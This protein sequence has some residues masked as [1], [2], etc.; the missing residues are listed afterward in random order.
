MGILVK[1]IRIRNFRS[2]ESLDLELGSTNLLIGQNNTGKSNF[3]CAVN[4]ALGLM[5]DFSEADIYVTDGE[6]LAKTKGATIDIYIYP[7]DDEGNRTA[8]FTDFWASVFTEKWIGTSLEGSFV[9][10]RAEI[11]LD[12]DRENYAVSRKCI[13]QWGDE[14]ERTVTKSQKD[15]FTDDMRQFISAFYM[16]ANRD[17]VQDLRNK[18]SFFGRVTSGSNLSEDKITKIESRL[19]AVNEMIIQNIPALQ[20]TKSR[21][22]AIG[23]TI[24]SESSS[25]EIEPLTRKLS[26]LNRGMDI[27]MKDGGANFSI[28]QNGHGT[29]SWISFLTLSAFVENQSNK[30]KDEDEEAEQYAMLT[31]EE[32]EA[33]LHP[34]A[35]RQLFAQMQDF[36][37]QKI[38]STHSPSIIAQSILADA[39][40]FYKENGRT[41][42][43]RYKALDGTEPVDDNMDEYILR[44]VINTRADILFSSA[45][46]LCEGITEE[47]AL[48]IFFHK[49]F[50]CAPFAH[51]VSIVNIGGAGKYLP[52]LTLLKNFNIPWA[53]FSDGESD[54]I[55][56]VSSAV[57]TVFNVD[58]TV[59]SNVV[60]LDDGQEYETY[61]INEGYGEAMIEAICEYEEDEDYLSNYM[62]RMQGQHR[63]PKIA[64]KLGLERTD[65]VRN[66]DGEAGRN[67]ALKEMCLGGKTIYALPVAKKIVLHTD[68]NKRIPTKIKSLFDELKNMLGLSIV[69]QTEE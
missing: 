23:K 22:S 27:V 56:A 54:A 2:I 10:I 6:R 63:K 68:V 57:T 28:S 30:I 1:H 33:H 5:T 53:I 9:G 52:Y 29:R 12:K 58:Y 36:T 47:L 49:H 18:K 13:T 42:A 64:E 20:E 32:P 3:L 43:K 45:V 25:V 34:Q 55:T 8:K 39:V 69:A 16:D 60:I 37:G 67:I 41:I 51:G 66:Y 31:M 11:K 50:G 40:Y 61:L 15:S 19:S 44:E 48:P 65:I 21:I 14:F 17:I 35:Q 62:A 4:V 24:G 59:C 7:T 46:I 38:I 26:D